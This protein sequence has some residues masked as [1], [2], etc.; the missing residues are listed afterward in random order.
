MF[1]FSFVVALPDSLLYSFMGGNSSRDGGGDRVQLDRSAARALIVDSRKKLQH[2]SDDYNWFM[3][4]KYMSNGITACSMITCF[5]A[6]VALQ[7]KFPT[8]ER[9]GKWASLAVGYVAGGQIHGLIDK[10]YKSKLLEKIQ[11]NM[12]DMEKYDAKYPHVSE[13]RGEIKALKQMRHQ[14]SPEIS[15]A[16]GSGAEKPQDSLESV[17]QDV[18]KRMAYR[19]QQSARQE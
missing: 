11:E 18:E 8:L 10:H 6:S 9:W 3:G 15:R 12:A 13:Y 14:L 4:H 7:S 1:C 19:R 16:A 5:G 17:L 2:P